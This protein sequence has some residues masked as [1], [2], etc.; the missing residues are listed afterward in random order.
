M[1]YKNTHLPEQ[2]I[3]ASIVDYED[4]S[5]QSRE[6]LEN[7]KT[8]C[9]QREALLSSL[10]GLSNTA[11]TFCPPV[12][13]HPGAWNMESQPRW[14]NVFTLP[15]PMFALAGT[16]ATILIALVLL[17]SPRAPVNIVRPQVPDM[18]VAAPRPYT[19]DVYEIVENT[20]PPVFMD[21]AGESYTEWDQDFYDFLVPE[22]DNETV[23][24]G[25]NLKG[26]LV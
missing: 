10:E 20:L 2:L 4:L 11:R 13:T 17:Q 3:I 26:A 9:A 21:L 5:E 7:C 8:C 1:S 12:S 14:W 25:N 19:E 23:T 24:L 16:L 6:H 22:A 18:A 15:K